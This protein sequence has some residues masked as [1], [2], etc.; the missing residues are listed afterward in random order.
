MP[1]DIRIPSPNSEFQQSPYDPVVYSLLASPITRKN[2]KKRRKIELGI[3]SSLSEESQQQCY[4]Y[5]DD[6]GDGEWDGHSQHARTDQSPAETNVV[7]DNRTETSL[8]QLVEEDEND[9]DVCNRCG[10]NNNWKYL[11]QCSYCF[12]WVHLWCYNRYMG[13]SLS[14]VPD[15]DVACRGEECINRY[16]TLVQ[17]KKFKMC[18]GCSLQPRRFL[19]NLMSLCKN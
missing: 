17:K 10:G 1:D 5:Q 7:D 12:E 18:I 14:T 6:A 4:D 16:K 3:D 13:L 11:F 8:S 9:P 2:H 15:G 19:P